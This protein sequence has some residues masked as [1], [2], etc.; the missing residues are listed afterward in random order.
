[1]DDKFKH[2]DCM[3]FADDKLRELERT[4]NAL[5]EAVIAYEAAGGE[6]RKIS[7][8]PDPWYKDMEDWTTLS[9]DP[10]RQSVYDVLF[11]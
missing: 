2:R 8:S 9:T 6:I 5:I 4:R 10:D 11:K 7:N 1:M 3:E